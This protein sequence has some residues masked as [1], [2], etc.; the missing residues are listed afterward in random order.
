MPRRA[1]LGG[2]PATKGAEAEPEMPTRHEDHRADRELAGEY[3]RSRSEPA[4]REIYRRHSPSVFG[5]ALRL[6]GY[7]REEAEEAVQE[8]WIR[9]CRKLPGFRWESSLRTWLCSIAVMC[10]RERRRAASRRP[11]EELPSGD[12]PMEAPRAQGGDALDLERAIASLPEKFRHVLILRDIQG[13]THREIGRL[14][15]I[16]PGTSKSQLFRARR[17]VR[18]ALLRA[19]ESQDAAEH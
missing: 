2:L 6:S 5:L 3:L 14:L 7:R 13:Y 11:E 10:L 15:E 17:A 8:T 19:E 9:A 1:T 12:L 18:Q 16:N 4:F